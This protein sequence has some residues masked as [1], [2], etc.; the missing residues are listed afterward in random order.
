MGDLGRRLFHPVL[1]G[2]ARDHGPASG[3]GTR[4]RH[5]LGKKDSFRKGVGD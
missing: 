2:Q 5:V 3:V 1:H 4:V